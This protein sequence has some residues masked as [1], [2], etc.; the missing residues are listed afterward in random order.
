MEPRSPPPDLPLSPAS[1][2]ESRGR[3]TP[4]RTSFGFLRRGKSMERSNTNRST[5]GGK[6][7]KK[8]QRARDEELHR[9]Q[10]EANAVPPKLPDVA[11]AGQLGAFDGDEFGRPSSMQIMSGQASRGS[12]HG[13]M[14]NNK[15]ASRLPD[16]AMDMTRAYVP[17]GVPIPPI[18]GEDS[19]DPYAR[20]ESMRNRG[21]YSYASS[22]ASAING[23]R[24]IKRR[25]DPTPFNLLVVGAHNTGKTS[26]LDFLRTSLALPAR[27]QSRLT[28]THDFNGPQHYSVSSKF[29]SQY[30]E[31]ELRDGERIGVT[32]WDSEGLDKTVVDLQ[33]AEISSFIESKFV[34]TFAEER[35]VVRTPD[36]RETHIHCVILMLDPLTLDSNV[37]KSKA[38]NAKHTNGVHI[39]GKTLTSSGLDEALD[40][41]VLRSLGTKTTVVPVIAKADTVTAERMI[42]LK[43]AVWDS[44]KRAGINPLEALDLDD[45]SS[46]G[47]DSDAAIDSSSSHDDDS[48]VVHRRS[49]N[50]RVK[51]DSKRFDERDEDAAVTGQQSM[52]SHLDSASEE[53]DYSQRSSRGGS[54]PPEYR[55]HHARHSST[56][57]PA[58]IANRSSNV[59]ANS[60]SKRT[61]RAG[62]HHQSN[63]STEPL[64]PLP[65]SVI[66]PDVPDLDTDSAYP[67]SEER[68]L[69]RVFPW[70]VADPM[71][72]KHCDF[73]KLRD[74]IFAEWRAELRSVCRE[75]WYEGWRSE[76][77]S[78]SKVA[79]GVPACAM[80]AAGAPPSSSGINLGSENHGTNRPLTASN[81]GVAPEPR[82][83]PRSSAGPILKENNSASPAG[84]AMS[85]EKNSTSAAEKPMQDMRQSQHQPQQYQQQQQ[86][87]PNHQPP[88]SAA[89]LG[90]GLGIGSS[91]SLRGSSP[92]PPPPSP[93]PNMTTAANNINHANPPLRPRTPSG[94]SPSL[95]SFTGNGSKSGSPMPGAFPSEQPQQQH[96]NGGQ[97]TPNRSRAPTM[98]NRQA[99]LVGDARREVNSAAGQYGN[100]VDA[101]GNLIAGGDAFGNGGGGRGRGG[102]EGIDAGPGY[103][104]EMKRSMTGGSLGEVGVAK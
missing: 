94:N 99:P 11:K 89:R 13:T 33:L 56:T 1:E 75:R 24:R 63:H 86:T 96:V 46:E 5:S 93:S 4:R 77:L 45:S 22:G 25:K 67:L 12:G 37:K 14:N 43:R 81:V 47:E 38:A 97:R 83:G 39:N 31:T 91:P 7:S 15:S 72:E 61:P 48:S 44:L 71:N 95:N 101:G 10:R 100:G 74:L 73:T 87:P 8:N 88:R 3:Q 76:R 79:N 51:H 69:V 26:F 50:R 34:N 17:K 29:S 52:T 80:S 103:P 40:I 58:S 49:R 6:L 16:G 57:I 19:Y 23:P 2:T 102:G 78:S 68:P 18:P 104:F 32:L 53:S 59:P 98:T 30:L 92:K 28:G 65:L 9:Q 85:K 41:N 20:T 27:K 35:K 82:A 55:G 84:K 70:G 42:V 54:M 36:H 21:R 66:S 62:N 60:S 90:P 64:P